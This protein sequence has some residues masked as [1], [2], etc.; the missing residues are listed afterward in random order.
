MDPITLFSD[1]VNMTGE[2]LWAAIPKAFAPAATAIIA[3]ALAVAGYFK[4]LK[5]RTFQPRLALDLTASLVRMKGSQA[6]HV[7]VVI[8]NEGYTGVVL[9]PRYSQCLDIFIADNPVWE[10][11]ISIDDGVLLWHDGIR[12]H[13]QVDVLL[14]P[15]LA[16]HQ[17]FPYRDTY[18]NNGGAGA[19]LLVPDRPATSGQRVIDGYILEPGEQERRA[20]LVPV[21]DAAAYLLQLSV[22][23]CRHASRLSRIAHNSCVERRRSPDLW[24][25]RSIVCNTDKEE[26]GNG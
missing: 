15:G 22:H 8:K 4:F 3:L 14:E 6:L 11:A 20:L 17:V 10:D 25:S 18:K 9:D 13:R 16:T 19:N 5:G 7:E 1:G 23:A 26:D 12:P 24:Q 21:H 2:P